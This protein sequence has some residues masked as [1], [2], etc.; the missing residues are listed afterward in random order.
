M[1]RPH[2]RAPGPRIEAHHL[3]A[4][5]QS[6]QVEERRAGIVLPGRLARRLLAV[7]NC[8]IA[9]VL[10][11]GTHAGGPVRSDEEGGAI[12]GAVGGPLRQLAQVH[13]QW[14][15]LHGARPLWRVLGATRHLLQPSWNLEVAEKANAPRV[16]EGPLADVDAD[17]VLTPTPEPPRDAPDLTSQCGLKA[18]CMIGL[19]TFA[20]GVPNYEVTGHDVYGHIRGHFHELLCVALP[21]LAEPL[22]MEMHCIW[23]WASRHGN[24]FK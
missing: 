19:K 9:R 4:R 8:Q 16:F 15:C 18:Q 24:T 12:G 14:A 20:V 23:R 2:F 13:L 6:K 3:M 1:D 5:R 22:V 7:H 17:S 21:V 10:L 11:Q